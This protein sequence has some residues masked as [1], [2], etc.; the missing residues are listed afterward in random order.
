MA[1]V[2]TSYRLGEMSGVFGETGFLDIPP[3]LWCRE[4]HVDDG[5]NSKYF[6]LYMSSSISATR[7]GTG[8]SSF[9]RVQTR[10][11]LFLY[12]SRTR[13][14]IHYESR[15]EKFQRRVSSYVVGDKPKD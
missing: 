7:K 3:S 9:Y 13:Q 6:W 5:K 2:T 8:K 15:S 4:P 14:K 1:V 12:F 11:H 10:Q